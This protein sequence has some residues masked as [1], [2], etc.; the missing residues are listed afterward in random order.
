[1][2]SIMIPVTVVRNGVEFTCRES[3]EQLKLFLNAGY[4]VKTEDEP[5]RKKPQEPKR[6]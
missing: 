5:K 1:M 3:E 2:E 4:E 6:G